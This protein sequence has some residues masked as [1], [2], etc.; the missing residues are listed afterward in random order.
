MKHFGSDQIVTL[1]KRLGA[2]E[3]EAISHPFVTSAI[4]NAQEKIEK[5]VQRDMPTESME[6]WF[7]FNMRQDL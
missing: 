4:R 6:D 3:A 1:F 7:R 2:D 5:K